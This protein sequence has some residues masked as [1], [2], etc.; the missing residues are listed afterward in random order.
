MKNFINTATTDD[1]NE[2]LGSVDDDDA[3]LRNSNPVS[4]FDV[5]SAWEDGADDRNKLF[6]TDNGAG[7]YIAEFTGETGAGEWVDK[8]EAHNIHGKEVEEVI[9]NAI[10]VWGAD[11]LSTDII[12]ND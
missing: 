3:D 10:F 5:R 8:E 1:I 6:I 7:G 2:W 4:E 9:L 12:F 11:L